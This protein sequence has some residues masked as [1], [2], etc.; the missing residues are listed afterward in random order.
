MLDSFGKKAV[1][2]NVSTD[3]QRRILKPSLWDYAD[4]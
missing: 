4:C 1:R 3:I 2:S